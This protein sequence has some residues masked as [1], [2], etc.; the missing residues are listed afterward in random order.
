MP[1][2]TPEASLKLVA[3]ISAIDAAAWDACAGP[4]NPFLSHAFLLALEQSGSAT[5]DAGWL[6]QHLVLEEAGWPSA[7]RRAAVPRGHSQGEYVF[8]H[9]LAQARPIEQGGRRVLS[10]AAVG[11][12]LHPGDGAAAV[13][14][15][16]RAVRHA[17][18]C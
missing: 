2:G 17:P 7:R 4:D 14:A 13:G 3:D 5:A 11:G 16:R 12:A 8:D 10:Q 9:E 1:D 15:P 6:P 18:A